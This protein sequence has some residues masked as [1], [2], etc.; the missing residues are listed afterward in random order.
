MNRILGV[1]LTL[2]AVAAQGAAASRAQQPDEHLR[3]QHMAERNRLGLLAFCREQGLAGEDALTAQRRAVERLPPAQDATLGDE[4]EA[5]GR[6]GY[7]AF[8]RRQG[9]LADSASAQ[10]T[11]LRWAC[12]DLA[13]VAIRQAER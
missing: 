1:V 10:G 2:C 6:L 13:A 11:S 12:K 4:E 3:S 5:A 7:L 9:R 8:G